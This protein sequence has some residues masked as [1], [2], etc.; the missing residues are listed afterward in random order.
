MGRG[1][2]GPVILAKHLAFEHDPGPG[3][4]AGL[5]DHLPGQL[6]IF[7]LGQVLPGLRRILH[8]LG[9]VG[10]RPHQRG[11]RPELGRDLRIGI[12]VGRIRRRVV[13]EHVGQRLHQRAIGM[14]DHVGDQFAGRSLGLHARDE[15]AARRA[16]HLDLDLGKALV[17][18]LDDLL[19][20]LGEIRG[21]E[22]Q[23]AFGLR[24]C[25][26]F[27]R[28]ELLR[29]RRC[30]PCQSQERRCRRLRQSW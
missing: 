17:E 9:I 15:L 24:R 4:A 30:A 25:N 23:L 8:Q 27:G 22:D 21:V 11:A 19:F 12:V 3:G 13:L 1:L 5:G 6:V 26:Q 10:D 28:S 2:L 16:H 18:G 29:L 14:I 7:G 20:D